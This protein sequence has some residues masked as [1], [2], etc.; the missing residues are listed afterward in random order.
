MPSGTELVF[1]G[2]T[3][4]SAAVNLFTVGIDGIGLRPL[5]EDGGSQPAP[6]STGAI[7]FVKH[8]D[9]YLLARDRRSQRRLTFR[10]GNDPDCSPDGHTI[11]FVR[12]GAVYTIGTDGRHLRRVASSQTPP[13]NRDN[14]C[15]GGGLSRGSADAVVFAPDGRR[16][17]FLAHYSGSDT[18]CYFLEVADLRGHRAAPPTVVASDNGINDFGEDYAGAAGL[19]WQPLLGAHAR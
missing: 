7:A 19:S 11:A 14:L 8:G 16:I 9:V 15:D 13:S 12:R 6:C 1:D 17:A 2:R 4:P 10:A 5:T 3:S 18:D